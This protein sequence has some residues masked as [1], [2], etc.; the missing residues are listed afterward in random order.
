MEDPL[1][2]YIIQQV[3]SPNEREVDEILS[4]FRKKYFKKGEFFKEPFRTGKYLAFLSKGAVRVIIYKNSGEE[5]TARIR[6][7]NSFMADPYRLDESFQI[8][9]MEGSPIGV[10]C[11]EDLILQIAPIEKILELLETNLA[12]NIVIRKHL[13][14]QMLI[15]A[16]RQY[17]FMAGTAKERY[18]Y[19][20][21]NNPRLLRKFPLRFIASMIGITPTQLSRIRNNISSPVNSSDFAPM[22]D[23]VQS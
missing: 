7:E 14:E 11:L 10:Q 2:R 19:I 16:N 8:N 1:K 4:L 17:L 15:L 18:Q 22:I 5:I 23:L 6:Q 20:L 21:E 3:G 12:L 9:G 13:R